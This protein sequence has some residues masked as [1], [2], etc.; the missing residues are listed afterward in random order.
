MRILLP[1]VLALPPATASAVTVQ[2]IVSLTKAGV[3]EQVILAVI[4]RDKNIFTISPEQ[5]IT[6]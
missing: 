1:V 2:E 4:E 6:L 5:L 3:S